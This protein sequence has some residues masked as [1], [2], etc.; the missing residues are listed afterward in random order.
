MDRFHITARKIFW[1]W[2]AFVAIFTGALWLFPH[3]EVEPPVFT[4]II[5]QALLFLIALA[6]VR[7]ESHSKNKFVFANFALLFSLSLA[8]AVGPFIG[9][10]YVL[11]ADYSFARH[12]FNTYVLFGAYGFLLALSLVYLTVDALFREFKTVQKYLIALSVVGMFFGLYFHGFLLN[13]KYAYV[14]QDVLDWKTMSTA[15][16]AYKVEHG[17]YPDAQ[18]LAASTDMYVWESGYAVATLHPDARDARVAE[19]YPYLHDKNYIV[20]LSKPLMSYMISMSVIGI[21]FVLLFFGYQYMKDPP[22]GAYIEK[23]MFLFLLFCSMEVLHGWSAN[24]VLEWQSFSEILGVGQY[25]SVAVLLLIAVF[26]ALRLRFIMSVKGE[27]YEQELE[28]SPTAV[29]RWRDALDT[30]VVESFFNRKVVHGRLFASS[31]R[32]PNDSH[33]TR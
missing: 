25:V 17:T 7:K 4:N 31:G 10:N 27:F 5:T 24:K 3:A 9:P 8:A 28:Q 15:A 12:Y 29:T 30:I 18:Q 23:M 14:T 13:P 19:L 1:S 11:F 33:T 16:D 20:L 22:Q 6:I 21:G 26:F 32:K 2:I